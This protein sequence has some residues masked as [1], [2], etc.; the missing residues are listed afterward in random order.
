M[1]LDL[2]IPSFIAG[3][4]TFLAPCTFPLVP[5]YLGFISGV[6]LNRGRSQ[7]L[8]GG[9]RAKIFFNGV[10]YVLGF[11]TVFVSLGSVVGWLAGRLLMKSNLVL[12]YIGAGFV[13]F[14]GLLIIDAALE[15][16]RD[17]W[18]GLKII[19]VPFSRWLVA[20]HRVS[21]GR[22]VMPGRP[23]S[24]FL[25]GA[26]FAIGWTPCVGPVLGAI[27]TLAATGSSAWSGAFLLGV[28]ALG[29]GLP[30]LVL[31]A[32]I[33]YFIHRLHLLYKYL[34][35]ISLFGGLFVVA[36]GIMLLTRQL[37]YWT[38]WLGRMCNFINYDVLLN[39]L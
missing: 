34:P 30:F 38:F 20:E 36:L 25:F 23:M 32:G 33:G 5:G 22:Y 26:A 29:L 12:E 28:F 14:F 37:G 24:S 39:Y 11:G 35:A 10:M 21:V 6:S 16:Y 8:S 13:I 7:T 17:R 19:K 2:I 31:A 27:L 3:L 18:P 4:F 1:V 9:S 15:H